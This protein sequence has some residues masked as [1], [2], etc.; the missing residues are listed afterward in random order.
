MPA[1][2]L[3]PAGGGCL[4][5]VVVVEQVSHAAELFCRSLKS[6][7]LLAQLRLFGLFLV[8]YLVDIP[9]GFCLLIAL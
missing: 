6:F 1:S 8:Q 4:F 2:S 9:H 3:T 7:N 5:F